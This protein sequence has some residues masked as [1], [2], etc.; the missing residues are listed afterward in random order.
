MSITVNTNARECINLVLDHLEMRDVDVTKFQLWVKTPHDDSPYPLIG[1][2]FP[3]SIKYNNLRDTAQECGT[4]H[5]NNLYNNGTDIK[6]VLRPDGKVGVNGS[7]LEMGGKKVSKKARK[8][9]IRNKLFKRS[10]SKGD[11]VD[12]AAPSP[13]GILFGHPLFKLAEANGGA[14]PKP[15]MVS[16]RSASIASSSWLLE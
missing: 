3:L 12:G 7:L 9:P 4:E 1:H 13:P 11:S 10:A 5:L 6:F 8:S 16:Q 14:L 15:V 2:E